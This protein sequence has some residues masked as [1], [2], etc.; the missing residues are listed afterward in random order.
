MPLSKTLFRAASDLVIDLSC[1]VPTGALVLTDLVCE[2]SVIFTENL[3][4][5]NS[6]K[7]SNIGKYQHL[8]TYKM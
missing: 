5:R 4:I 8:K 7:I 2:I 3:L 1:L 6:K